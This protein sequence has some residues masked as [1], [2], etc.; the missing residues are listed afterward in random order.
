MY[1]LLFLVPTIAISIAAARLL[2]HESERMREQARASALDRITVIADSLKGAV[3]TVEDELSRTL[4]R[5]PDDGIPTAL[6]AWQSANPLVRNVFLWRHDKGLQYPATGQGSTRDE[7][8]FITRYEALFT[9]RVPWTSGAMDVPPGPEQKT[10]SSG[11]YKRSD[12][13]QLVDLARSTTTN[14][15]PPGTGGW[16]PWFSENQLHLLGWVQKKTGAPVYGLELEFMFLLS[17]MIATFP[18]KTPAGHVYAIVDGAGTI[19]HQSGNLQ[20]PAKSKPEV[21]ASLS[22]QLPH[23]SVVLFCPGG[24]A[25]GQSHGSFL[26]LSFLLLGIFVAAIILGGSLLT[27]QAHINMRDA[28]QKTS[29]VSNVSH[30]LKT[31]LTSIRMYAELLSQGRVRDEEKKQQ[32]LD[33]ISSESQRLTRLVNNVLDFGRLEEGKKKYRME[34]LDLSAFLGQFAEANRLR[35]GEAGLSLQVNTPGNA[36]IVHCDRDA[37]EQ[38]LLNLVDN[39]IK[40]AS[41][42]RELVME[43]KSLPGNCNISVMDRG[44]GVPALHRDKIFDKFHRVDDSLTASQPGSGLG[45][46]IA[47][48]LLRGMGGDL[49]YEP[50]QG[51]GSCFV[52]VLPKSI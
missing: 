19:I 49:L 6:Q 23:W 1:W 5:L 38:A 14:E 29:F 13:Q 37:I 39:A 26:L 32:Y 50:R 10:T 9:G 16:I 47:R 48:S 20:V 33:I 34:D 18:A 51:G 15:L 27:W 7:M 52:I 4:R 11:S 35:I 44:P 8:L 21:E 28:R 43:L 25:Q 41:A 12:R 46:T 24:I 45:L 2:V 36:I 40:Y 22:P 31:P 3:S 30:E 17:R 42:G